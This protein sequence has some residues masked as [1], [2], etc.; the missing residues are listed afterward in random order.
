MSCSQNQQLKPD[1]RHE[2][3]TC[4]PFNLTIALVKPAPHRPSGNIRDE[5]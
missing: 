1:R 4:D 2:L 5:G 3:K